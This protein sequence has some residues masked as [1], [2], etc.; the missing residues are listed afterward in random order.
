LRRFQLVDIA[1]KRFLLSSVREISR[2]DTT[3]MCPRKKKVSTKGAPKK[4]TKG[5]GK[6]SADDSTRRDPSYY[7]HVDRMVDETP[8]KSGPVPLS[9]KSTTRKR[10]RLPYIE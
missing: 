4:G 10:L 9:L 6:V 1:I 8:P 5:K 2:P 3:S 7:E